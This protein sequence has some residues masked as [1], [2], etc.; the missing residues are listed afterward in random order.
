MKANIHIYNFHIYTETSSERK[1]V[2]SPFSQVWRK[3]LEL[4]S[5]QLG[6]RLPPAGRGVHKIWVTIVGNFKG[7][8][9]ENRL[10]YVKYVVKPTS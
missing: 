5:G 3:I 8:E 7:N 1:T 9:D 10:F 4:N 2:K 6:N